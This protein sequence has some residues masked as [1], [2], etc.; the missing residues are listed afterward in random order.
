MFI[1]EQNSWLA[2]GVFT[3]FLA[4]ANLLKAQ[5]VEFSSVENVEWAYAP[6]LHMT[7]AAF[8]LR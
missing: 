8:G 7:L 4:W 5:A 6:L 2:N 1:V 3:P